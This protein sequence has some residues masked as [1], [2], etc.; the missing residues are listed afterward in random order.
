MKTKPWF[1]KLTTGWV[2]TARI[3]LLHGEHGHTLRCSAQE[4]SASREVCEL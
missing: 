1:D 2:R 3:P 4:K